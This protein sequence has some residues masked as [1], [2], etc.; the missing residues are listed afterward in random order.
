LP[1]SADRDAGAMGEPGALTAAINW[2]RAMPLTNMRRFV[3]KTIVPTMYVWS[4]CDIFVLA[5]GA[6][7]CGPPSRCPAGHQLGP[8]RMLVG[9]VPLLD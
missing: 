7:A 4:D 8:G 6:R 1:A 5:N 9:N 3:A 2:Y